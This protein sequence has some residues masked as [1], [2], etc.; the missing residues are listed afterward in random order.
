MAR[1][2]HGRQG[3]TGAFSDHQAFWDWSYTIGY[4]VYYIAIAIF[5]FLV[6]Q[7]L[8]RLGYRPKVASNGKEAVERACRG[9]GASRGRR[10]R[11]PVP[12]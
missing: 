3:S 2:R 8:R 5:L 9:A 11:P 7:M 12:V 1:D 6:T 4:G 10:S